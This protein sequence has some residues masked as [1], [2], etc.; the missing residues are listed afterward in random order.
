MKHTLIISLIISLISCS[1]EQT[2]Q[3]YLPKGTD[4]LPSFVVKVPVRIYVQNNVPD[5]WREAVIKAVGEWN[6]LKVVD[7]KIVGKLEESN[8]I[9]YMYEGS[10]SVA[11]LASVPLDENTP[12]SYIRLN[13]NTGLNQSQLVNR[14]IHEIGHLIGFKHLYSRESVFN[15]NVRLWNGWGNDAN[16]IKSY[17]N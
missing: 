5:Y 8:T 1:K 4:T 13:K 17:Y 3:T 11:A 2:E 7:F 12:G 16:F 10:I 6:S 15:F 9:I 14:A